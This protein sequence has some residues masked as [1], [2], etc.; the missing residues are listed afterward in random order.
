[1]LGRVGGKADRSLIRSRLVDAPDPIAKADLQ[2]ALAALGDRE[3]QMALTRNLESDNPS[4]RVFA[5]VFSGDARMTSVKPQLI[6]L[7]EDETLDVRIRAAQS[8]L[9]LAR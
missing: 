5:A 2:H 6:E 7:L 4:I 8:L 1:M 9:V 3:G